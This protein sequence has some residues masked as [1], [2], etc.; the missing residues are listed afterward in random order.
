MCLELTL[1]GEVSPRKSRLDHPSCGLCR[2]ALGNDDG[3]QMMSRGKSSGGIYRLKHA[4]CACAHE[5]A[6]DDDAETG[7]CSTHLP[8]HHHKSTSSQQKSPCGDDDGDGGGDGD[9]G[10]DASAFEVDSP[11]LPNGHNQ[12][13]YVVYD[14]AQV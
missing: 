7:N 11:L 3:T 14:V 1:V 10:D 12:R 4:C 9:G 13:Y 6:D 2:N 5:S 8:G